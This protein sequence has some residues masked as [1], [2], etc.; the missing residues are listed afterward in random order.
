MVFK[1]KKRVQEIKNWSAEFQHT[2][3]K[4]KG[5]QHIHITVKICTNDTKLPPSLKENNVQIV[6][7]NKLPF[8]G[9]KMSWS[10]ERGKLCVI[11][12]YFHSDLE[13]LVA[14]RLVHC[15]LKL[16]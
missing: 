5:N 3:D 12:T 7:N 10:P 15:M 4:A 2:V 11:C 1:V 13:V 16:C 6:N 8:L 14:L 9:M